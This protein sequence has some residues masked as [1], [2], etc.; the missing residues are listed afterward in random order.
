M[1]ITSPEALEEALAR[2]MPHGW[3]TGLLPAPWPP[4]ALF[5][6]RPLTLG[7]ARRLHGRAAL[8][9]SVDYTDADGHRAV[10]AHAV[11]VDP[12]RWRLGDEAG[13]PPPA[14]LRPVFQRAGDVA[15]WGDP[16][17]I[18]SI[19][20][21]LLEA[22]QVANGLTLPD[23][24]EPEAQSL[25]ECLERGGHRGRWVA[26]VLPQCPD[27]ELYVAPYD[28]ATRAAAQERTRLSVSVDRDVHVGLNMVK[29][30]LAATVRCGPGGPPLLSE[31]A[32]ARLPYGGAM[33]LH[34]VANWLVRAPE[35]EGR[36]QVRFRREPDAGPAAAEG[37][38]H[39]DV[40]D[41]D[42]P[43]PAA[44]GDGGGE[45]AGADGGDGG[46]GASGDGAG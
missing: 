36:G 28:E 11:L 32:A 41:G 30:M 25:E 7:E 3:A 43:E 35:L 16:M 5:W 8:E 29:P 6:L 42:A 46:V 17:V 24:A 14:A 37:A 18:R 26:G 44:L 9:R 21:R 23:V 1:R 15:E 33:A 39:P 2:P 22:V 45:P 10:I 34:C 40:V 13:P 12:E 19:A 4:D 20:F 27:A 38:G 31:A